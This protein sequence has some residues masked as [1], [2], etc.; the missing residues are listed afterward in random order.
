MGDLNGVSFV[1][2]TH[3]GILEHGG[4]RD[5]SE[6]LRYRHPVP[7]APAWEGAYVDDRLV[8]MV[9]PKNRLR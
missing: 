5:P 3:E 9:L 8:S 7:R 1:Q 6:R 2:S 4:C